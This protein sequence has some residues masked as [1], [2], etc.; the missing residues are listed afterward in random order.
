MKSEKTRA[1]PATLEYLIDKR[2]MR[3]EQIAVDLNVSFASIRRWMDGTRKPKQA[4][5]KQIEHI[6]GVKIS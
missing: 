3:P 1:L 2:S 4:T 5:V 6:Y